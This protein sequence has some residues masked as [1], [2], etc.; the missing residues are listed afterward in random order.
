MRQK[1]GERSN[2]F[3]MALTT[4]ALVEQREHQP[5]I[6]AKDY[7]AALDVLRAGA[8]EVSP[9]IKGLM[10]RYAEVLKTLHRDREA[11]MLDSQA[12]ALRPG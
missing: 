1:F 6:A 2:A 5:G 9:A 7:E 12:K 3:A 10:Q 8:P 4:R 11:K